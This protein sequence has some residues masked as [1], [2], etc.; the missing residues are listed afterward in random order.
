MENENKQDYSYLDNSEEIDF[1]KYVEKFKRGWTRARNNW[2]GVLRFC[3][4]FG[5]LGIVAAFTT[6]KTYTVVSS[7]APEF[8]SKSGSS[9]SSMASMLGLS[10]MISSNLSADAVRPDLYPQ[11]LSSKQFTY[12]LFDTKLDIPQKNGDTLHTTYYEYLNEHQKKSLFGTV[13]SAPFTLLGW[14]RESLAPIDEGDALTVCGSADVEV[15][16]LS[17]K[18]ERTMKAIH[19]KIKT[20]FDKKTYVVTI[21]V[22]DQNAYVAGIISRTIIDNLTEYITEYRTEKAKKDFEYYTQMHADAEAEYYKAQ[23]EFAGFVDANMGIMRESQMVQKQR[24]QDEMNLKYQLYVTMSQQMLQAQAQVQQEKPVIAVLEI[25]T[26][27]TKGTPSKMS[28]LFK[29]I[30]FGFIV[31]VFWYAKGKNIWAE[32]KANKK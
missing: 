6:P 19:K 16:K 10:S 13:V 2:R 21:T 30:I 28:V 18:Q 5:I 26:I 31:G 24:L 14:I 7:I 22:K 17:N 23:D 9:L 11:L 32:K 27:P 12:D 29:W 15:Y 20:S 3:T 8:T 4:V 25:P 1:S